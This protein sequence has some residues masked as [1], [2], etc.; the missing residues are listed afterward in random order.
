MITKARKLPPSDSSS[1]APGSSGCLN[2]SFTKDFRQE[3][4]EA[5]KR[6]SENNVPENKRITCADGYQANAQRFLSIQAI[7]RF[8]IDQSA[9]EIIPKIV[10]FDD[11]KLVYVVREHF[12]GEERHARSMI[13]E[14]FRGKGSSISFPANVS[15]RLEVLKEEARTEGW[16]VEGVTHHYLGYLLQKSRVVKPPVLKE[17]LEVR[18][19]TPIVPPKATKP[20]T[21]KA[22]KP[23]GNTVPRGRFSV[24]GAELSVVDVAPPGI[25]LP[26]SD[27]KALHSVQSDKASGIESSVSNGPANG[28]TFYSERIVQLASKLAKK[29]MKPAAVTEPGHPP[30]KSPV[31]AGA[32]LPPP[33]V[34]AQEKLPDRIRELEE[35]LRANGTIL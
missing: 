33:V 21:F 30:E 20:T 8:Q 14:P 19:Q 22:A 28:E 4:K 12:E 17:F 2:S 10:S 7:N 15:K 34:V 27:A 18:A 1:S 25:P 24:P 35:R 6:V 29:T 9:F 23:N 3:A 26:A 32:N 16:S 11:R 31:E 5:E 13:D